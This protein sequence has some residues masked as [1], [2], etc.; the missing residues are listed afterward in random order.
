MDISDA[1]R[2][3][4]LEELSSLSSSSSSS[5]LRITNTEKPA[6]EEDWK[7]MYYEENAVKEK[8][9]PIVIETLTNKRLCGSLEKRFLREMFVMA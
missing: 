9:C 1:K 3:K 8:D 7:E 2:L 5:S 6:D 4:A